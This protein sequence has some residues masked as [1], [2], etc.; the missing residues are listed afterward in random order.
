MRFITE[1]DLREIYKNA[2]FTTYEPKEGTRLTPGAREFLGDRGIRLYDEVKT[3]GYG[4]RG[5][6]GGTGVDSG[7]AA[8]CGTGVHSGAAGG[9]GH[10]VRSGSVGGGGHE[11][12]PG[13][14]GGGGH[15]ARFGSAGGG[16]HEARSGSAGG[17]GRGKEADS[18]R[19]AFRSVQALFLQIGSELLDL[20]VLMAQE[21][22]ALERRLNE[23]ASEPSASIQSGLEPEWVPCTGIRQENVET[24]LEDCFEI[25]GFHAQTEK[26]RQ[27]VRLHRLRCALRELE[28]V[29]ELSADRKKRLNR[30][31]NRLSQMICLAFGGKTCQKK[32]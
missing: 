32:E 26:G 31:I 27:I 11:A 14:A 4:T 20:D 21:V 28:L 15:E 10:E 1:D 8:G 13:S 29:P 12:R 30:I 25:T 22:F 16:G 18:V 2:P 24:C 23:L 19:S 3:P 5:A 9:C 7:Q 17:R 6:C